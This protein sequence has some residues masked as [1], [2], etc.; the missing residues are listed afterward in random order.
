[1]L[2]DLLMYS[3]RKLKGFAMLVP[4]LVE[5]KHLCTRHFV[6][7]FLTRCFRGD[8]ST[9][10]IWNR[11]LTVEEIESVLLLTGYSRS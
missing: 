8:V 4:A 9:V 1:M 5:G 10:L 11:A 6:F 3:H 2:C 7:S